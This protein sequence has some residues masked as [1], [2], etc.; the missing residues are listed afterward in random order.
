[1]ALDSITPAELQLLGHPSPASSFFLRDNFFLADAEGDDEERTEALLEEVAA[2][3][4]EGQLRPAGMS[5][6]VGKWKDD[7]YRGDEMAW[8]STNGTSSSPTTD[9]ETALG[10]P[11]FSV[12]P[13]SHLHALLQ[14]LEVL[15]DH[16]DAL[17]RSGHGPPLLNL[18]PSKRRSI[19]LAYYPGDGKRYVR[20]RDAFPPDEQ[21]PDGKKTKL[22]SVR[23]LTVIYY[24]NAEW[25]PSQGGEL[26]LFLGNGDG[27]ERTWDVA[28]LLDRVV[29]FRS[30]VVEH[31]VLATHGPRY[32]LTCWF[33][34]R[35][36]HTTPLP[37][38]PAP[39]PLAALALSM[40]CAAAATP[41]PTPT[42]K[43]TLPSPAPLVACSPPRARTRGASSSAPPLDVE[44]SSSG[45]SQ[46]EETATIF[47][48]VASYRDSECQ[49]TLQNLFKTAMRSERI[50]V[51]VVWQASEEEDAHCFTH[52]LP[53]VWAKQVRTLKMDYREA[54]GPCWARHLAQALWQGESYV[55]Q[56]DSHM[57]FRPGWDVYLLQTL[58]QTPTPARSILTTYPIGYELPNQCP[59][60]V[61]PTLLCPSTFDEHGILRQTARRAATVPELPLP[62]K[63]WA[64]GFNFA[65][66]AAWL[67]VPYDPSLRLLFF[68]EEI[69]MA[70]RLYTHGWDFYAPPETVLYHLWSR[71]HRPT[72]REVKDEKRVAAEKASRRRVQRLLGFVVAEEGEAD[73]EEGKE[74]VQEVVGRY[75]LGNARTLRAYERLLGVSFAEGKVTSSNA[76]WGGQPSDFFEGSVVGEGNSDGEAP[77]PQA[78]KGVAGLSA[79]VNSFLL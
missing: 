15:R 27:E 24:L 13:D 26:R 49:H 46:E 31:E 36:T 25:E 43:E 76:V 19:Q 57:R 3:Q 63:L 53:P 20:H 23:C 42:K 22:E 6:S 73:E 1:M 74:E 44:A 62:S 35:P 58:Q 8:L 70:A 47:V 54:A 59:S 52:P 4:A 66:A 10:P 11:T 39:S 60:D 65:P 78:L 77:V 29:V 33:Y 41:A 51:G 68:G 38:L 71:R 79:L 48:S 16:I 67:E 28:P 75:G 7:E 69:S 45:S 40:A 50:F 72:F 32:A 30:D 55:L 56:I 18:D 21:A 64:S 12:A 14:R 2:V 9:D 37:S 61:R 17:D 5:R 34:G